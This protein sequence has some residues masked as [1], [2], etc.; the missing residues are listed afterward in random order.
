V[1]TVA[2]LSRVLLIAADV[3]LAGA[4]ALVVRGRPVDVAPASD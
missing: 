3:L 4:T 2:L 1:L